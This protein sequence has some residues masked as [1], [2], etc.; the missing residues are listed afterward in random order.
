MDEVTVFTCGPEPED[1]FSAVYDAWAS[2]L[3]HDHVEL[4]VWTEEMQTR[5]FAVYRP[6]ERDLE[7]AEKVARSVRR[8]I[9]AQAWNGIYQ[10]AL[11]FSPDRADAVYRFLIRGFQVGPDVISR[12]QDPAVYRLFELSRKVGR[13]SH[14]FLEF[15]R[16]EQWP[17]GMLFARLAP[18]CNVL[19]VIA[20]H[21]AGRLSGEDWMIYDETRRRAAVHPAGQNW[22]LMDLAESGWE[23]CFP[24]ELDQNPH[25]L[26]SGPADREKWE[27]LWRTF[28]K[29]IAIESRVNPS[30][31][32]NL[33]P[34][35]YRKHMT[36]H[37]K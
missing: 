14:L 29:S 34:L 27:D 5:L 30:L 7:K 22:F 3:G 17:D 19:P 11:S 32:R 1:I 28:V 31:Q 10:A 16:F 36:E 21:F 15:V 23:E 6:V 2:G 9:S 24:E 4:A 12:L 33:M 35:W 8:R 37:L 18:K 13:E 26:R 20:P 25:S